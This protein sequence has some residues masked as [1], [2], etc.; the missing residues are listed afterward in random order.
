MVMFAMRTAIADRKQ[1]GIRHLRCIL[2]VFARYA[3]LIVRSVF[4][5]AHGS[6]PERAGGVAAPGDADAA[7][8]GAISWF[9]GGDGIVRF[10]AIVIR[11]FVA[12]G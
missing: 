1:Q 3:P 10:C 4:K 12:I 2:I 6:R 8:M 7:E 11:F 5:A 9:E